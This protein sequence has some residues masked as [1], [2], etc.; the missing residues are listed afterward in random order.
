MIPYKIVYVARHPDQSNHKTQYMEGVGTSYAMGLIFLL[1]RA[2]RG[3]P[4]RTQ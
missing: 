3:P 2:S 1:I 4:L